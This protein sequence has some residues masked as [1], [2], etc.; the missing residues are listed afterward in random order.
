MRLE[1]FLHNSSMCNLWLIWLSITT[2][3]ILWE[4]TC[5]TTKSKDHHSFCH[6]YAEDFA[7]LIF[8][9]ETH[10]LFA[11]F[12]CFPFKS[13][14]QFCL[15]R[16]L[17]S[18]RQSCVTSTATSRRWTTV[19]PLREISNSHFPFICKAWPSADTTGSL[20]S[21]KLNSCLNELLSVENY[22]QVI[23]K[24]VLNVNWPIAILKVYKGI[25]VGA[26]GN[27]K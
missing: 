1:S 20:A 26:T 17:I 16:N 27:K 22:K 24:Q 25:G 13:I 14:V 9:L 3:K 12:E 8:F 5:S 23:T 18:S 19:I 6:T 15:P 2:P 4:E 21:P 7:K 11:N 10:N